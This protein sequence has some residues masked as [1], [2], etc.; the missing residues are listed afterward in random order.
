MGIKS[1]KANEP[2]PTLLD[3]DEP[4]II[5]TTITTS[6]IFNSSSLF[7]SELLNAALLGVASSRMKSTRVRTSAIVVSLSKLA[8]PT[9]NGTAQAVF[10]ALDSITP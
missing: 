2:I 1:M 10:E 8:S 9:A 3:V 5:S 7:T 6:A 4:V